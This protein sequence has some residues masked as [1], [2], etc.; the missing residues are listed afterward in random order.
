M[1]MNWPPFGD[2]L[3]KPPARY[4]TS[5]SG[6]SCPQWRFRPWARPCKHVRELRAAYGIIE[7]NRLKWE[8]RSDYAD[9]D[10]D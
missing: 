7:A 3:T 6:C 1:A 10:A 8:K 9:T 2:T 5:E 4:F